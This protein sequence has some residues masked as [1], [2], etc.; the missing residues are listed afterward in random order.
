MQ[1]IKNSTR[2]IGCRH[3]AVRLIGARNE[4]ADTALSGGKTH[5]AIVDRAVVKFAAGVL[6]KI[7]KAGSDLADPTPFRHHEAAFR[8]KL[9]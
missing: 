7:K 9:R 6:A 3:S 5:F 4:I 8:G 2:V 1:T